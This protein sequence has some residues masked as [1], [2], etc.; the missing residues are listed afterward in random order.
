MFLIKYILVLLAVIFTLYLI[1]NKSIESAF[2]V[3]FWF[4]SVFFTVTLFGLL[5]LVHTGF[6]PVVLD[7]NE[8]FNL[9]CVTGVAIMIATF[10]NALVILFLRLLKLKV[11]FRKLLLVKILFFI[12]VMITYSF[13]YYFN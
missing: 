5:G 11:N 2:V 12:L 4:T 8:R 9:Y 3:F 10:I 1:N 6:D 13:H 7:L